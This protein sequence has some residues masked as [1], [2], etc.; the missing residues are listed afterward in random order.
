MSRISKLVKKLKGERERVITE[1]IGSRQMFAECKVR[2]SEIIKSNLEHL[3]NTCDNV[4]ELTHY[5]QS[6]YPNHDMEIS[7]IDEICGHKIDLKLNVVKSKYSLAFMGEDLQ[8]MVLDPC[9]YFY[10]LN[11]GDFII[12]DDT[13]LENKYPTLLRILLLHEECHYLQKLKNKEKIIKVYTELDSK[14]MLNYE[15]EA[16]KYALET[17]FKWMLD[18]E[19]EEWWSSVSTPSLAATSYLHFL[20]T[21]IDEQREIADLRYQFDDKFLH[22]SLDINLEDYKKT[23]DYL[24]RINMEIM[25]RR[26]EKIDKLVDKYY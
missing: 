26:F 9:M 12:I 13:L 4:E 18:L 22:K 11:C 15:V 10:T 2:Y 21:T 16:D 24:M 14:E 3:I 8:P 17:T 23:T 5:F 7:K 1:P 25:E 20:S 6:L 19:K